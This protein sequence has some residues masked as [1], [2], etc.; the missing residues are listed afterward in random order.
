MYV[1][2]IWIG[3]VVFEVWMKNEKMV[4]FCENE[5]DDEFEVNWCYDSMFV[6]C[7][8]AFWCLL[9]SV[10]VLGSKLGSRGSKKGTLG[11][12]LGVPEREQ[13]KQGNYYGEILL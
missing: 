13:P 10:W 8:N 12:K 6:V 5:L 11:G 3:V 1:D 2:E 4:V 7:L 9:T